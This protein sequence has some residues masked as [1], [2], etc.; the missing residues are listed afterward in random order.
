MDNAGK[1]GDR[2]WNDANGDG[3]Q[4]A[5]EPG[6]SGVTVR[7]YA[8]DG[9]T[10]LN[11]LATDTSGNYQFVGLAN[12]TYVVKVDTAT[13]PSGYTQTGYGD[14]GAP[15]GGS[16]N[17]QGTT[18]V[19]GGNT[20][21]NV[22]FGY[23][24]PANTYPVNGRVW[25]DLDGNGAQNGA[26]PGIAGVTVCL[27]DSTG[28][29]VVACTTTQ[30]TT[31][32]YTF[33]GTP[34]GTY[35]IKVDPTTMPA[36]GFIQTGDP[37][38]T[39]PGA[40]CDNKSQVTVNN[41][42]V[43]NQNF[44]YQQPLSSISGTVCY[45][46]GN[47]DCTTGEPVAVGVPVYLTYAG[48][49]G[50]FGT[51]DDVT[52]PTVTDGSGNYTFPNLPGGAYQVTKLDPPGATSL[53]DADGGN[54]NNISIILTPGQNKPN[55]DFEMLPAPAAIGD[56]VW[57]DENGNGLQDAG[58]DGIP[59]VKAQLYAANGTT[60]LATTYTDANGGYLF[61]GLQAGTYVVKVDPA[62]LPA[63]LAA[64][65][66]YDEDGV[67]TANQATVTAGDGRRAPDDG[68]R[69]QLGADVA[70]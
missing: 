12:A 15:C 44:G 45:G 5:G 29:N 10:L 62:S 69:L 46:N 9:T 52:T 20:V 17:N 30:V 40:A 53:A 33:P 4:T 27:Y 57:L 36:G 51:P 3:I 47:G 58:E 54:P 18:T 55:Q 38:G 59:N 28:T 1:I 67:G 6:I 42:P 49:D 50:I 7:L 61:P 2:V 39:C 60:L 65:P 31:G 41:T 68:L 24:P 25:K 32:D 43:T 8:A 16:C 34:N 22:D 70:T 64:N 56:R 66:T 26:E 23:K 11:T 48:P 13:L 37:N 35:V 19:S 21:T 14:P 63:G